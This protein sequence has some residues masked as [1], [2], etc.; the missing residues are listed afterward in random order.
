MLSPKARTSIT[1][2]NR[3]VMT[4]QHT[5]LKVDTFKL[6]QLISVGPG[7]LCTETALIHIFLFSVDLLHTFEHPHARVQQHPDLISS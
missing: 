2:V 1:V 6:C 7:A 5:R 3:K 4:I